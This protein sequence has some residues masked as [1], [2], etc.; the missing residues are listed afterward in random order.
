MRW[1]DESNVKLW[2]Q[3]DP[4]CLEKEKFWVWPKEH[5]PRVETLSFGAV[6]LLRIQD[7][8]TALRSQGQGHIH[9]ILGILFPQP[10]HWRTLWMDLV[11]WQ[12]PKHTT[13]ATMEWLNRKHIKVIEWPFQSP[14]LNPNRKSVKGTEA[15]RCQV[16]AKKPLNL[17]RIRDFLWREVG[18]NPSCVQTWW[19]VTINSLLLW[20]PTKVSP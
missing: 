11:A 2:H 10:E 15:L 13:K 12:W 14:D 20:L 5:H 1:S 18:Q 7:D 8:I 4:P 19:P 6:F 9:K 17:E 3:L 16:S